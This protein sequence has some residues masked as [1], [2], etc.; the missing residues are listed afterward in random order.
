MWTENT[1]LP[2]SSSN[3]SKVL[4]KEWRVEGV[5]VGVVI[6]GLVLRCCDVKGEI[7]R[8]RGRDEKRGGV[9]RE[10]QRDVE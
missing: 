2:L 6:K 1:S 5:E 8:E 3:V 10:R 9:E 7:G 4:Y